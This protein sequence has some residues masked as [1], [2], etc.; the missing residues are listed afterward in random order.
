MNLT[1]RTLLAWLDDTLP[2]GEVREIGRKVNEAPAAQELVKRIQKVSRRRRL[3]VPSSSGPDGVDANVV[4]AYLDNQLNHEQVVE[5]EKKCLTSDLHLAE[6]AASH[7]ILSMIGQKAKVPEAAKQR[8]YRLV[9]GREA[10]GQAPKKRRRSRERAQA[11]PIEPQTPAWVAPSADQ[12]RGISRGVAPMAL[13]AGLLF[14]LVIS[15]LMLSPDRGATPQ[16]QQA[17]SD[18]DAA[19]K[20]NAPPKIE[21]KKPEQPDPAELERKRIEAE[22]AEA[23]AKENAKKERE[24]KEKQAKLAAPLPPGIAGTI[25]QSEGVL[26]RF[27][28]AKDEWDRVNVKATLHEGDRLVAPMYSRHVVQWG[29]LK[30]ALLGLFSGKVLAADRDGTGRI[31]LYQGRVIVTG[32]APAKPF[33]VRLEGKD[34]SV[35]A[36]A[37][38]PVGLQRAAGPNPRVGF[39]AAEGETTIRT[40]KVEETLKGPGF[41]DL[42]LGEKPTFSPLNAMPSPQWVTDGRLQPLDQQLADDLSKLLKPDAPVIASLAEG[43]GDPRKEIREASIATLG[44]IGELELVITAIST[45]KDPA[46]RHAAIMALNSL[47]MRNQDSFI[48]I[49]QELNR[50]QGESRGA[51]FEKLIVGF[52][53]DESADPGTQA[54]LVGLLQDSDVG[55]REMALGWLQVLTRRDTLGFNPDAPDGPG[56]EAWKEVLSKGDAVPKAAVTRKK[57]Q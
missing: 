38:I 5:Y 1:L 39:W 46:A 44:E 34:V 54:K 55:V 47:A 22:K 40:G 23:E 19:S 43:M 8:M 6:V 48:T 35:T 57:A 26:L 45:P 30:V 50:L 11:A 36:P 51:L 42:V 4:A 21:E 9:K 27:N 3:S 12:G 10:V 53:P 17:S 14:L 37:E 20:K 7:Q 13:I 32:I 52:T 56:L 15:V 29:P 28:K 16:F 33:I 25:D 2:P 31:E 24:E 18:D 49:R 41:I